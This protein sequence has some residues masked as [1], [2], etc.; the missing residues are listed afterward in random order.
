MFFIAVVSTNFNVIVAQFG[1]AL[2]IFSESGQK[3]LAAAGALLNLL[4]M[5]FYICAVL[6]LGRGF[7]ILPE[8]NILRVRGIFKFSRHPLYLTYMFWAATQ[9]LI[10]QTWSIIIFSA[11]QISLYVI[12]AKSE[13]N[14]L[15]RTF[16]EYS[17]YKRSV[18]WFGRRAS[19]SN[20]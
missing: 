16:P 8:A 15:E 13:E 3:D 6:T 17:E 12:R 14:L 1:D 10:Y 4:S 5:P 2:P 20:V 9:I 19:R 11:I 18:M 7:S